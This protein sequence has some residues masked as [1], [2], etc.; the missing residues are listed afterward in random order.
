M[1][2]G[3]TR[4]STR[5]KSLAKTGGGAA[6]GCDLVKG[7]ADRRGARDGIGPAQALAKT[8]NARSETVVESRLYRDLV[9]R[10][11]KWFFRV[12]ER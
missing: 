11:A 8:I 7:G 12:E 6:A 9:H 5:T 4:V 3:Y 2:I 10:P 1:K